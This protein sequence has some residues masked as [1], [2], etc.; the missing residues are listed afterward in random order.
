MYI[1]KAGRAWYNVL[2]TMDKR[3][4][5]HTKEH[6]KKIGD[7]LRGHPNYLINHSAKTMRQISLKMGG[8]GEAGYRAVHLWVQKWKGIPKKCESCGTEKAK[9]YEWAN[10][11]HKYC[12]VLED[13]IRMCTSCHRKYD[14]NNFD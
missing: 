12:R 14:Y 6:K 9:K 8:T 3:K 4:K 13:Y 7:K 11:D 1:R 2:I 5:P 10:I